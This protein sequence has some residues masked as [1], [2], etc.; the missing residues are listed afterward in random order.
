LR[1]LLER[2]ECKSKKVPTQYH[3]PPIFKTPLPG[4]LKIFCQSIPLLLHYFFVLAIDSSTASQTI[5]FCTT[6]FNDERSVTLS[7]PS[8]PSLP[9]HDHSLP[10]ASLLPFFLV[11]Q[12]ELKRYKP[13]GSRTGCKCG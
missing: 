5:C 1:I 3:C 2:K 4:D 12:M 10:F 6:T 8:C 7:S 13:A 11:N 9:S